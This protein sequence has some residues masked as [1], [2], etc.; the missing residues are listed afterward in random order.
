MK[1]LGAKTKS[2]KPKMANFVIDNG[3]YFDSVYES[4]TPKLPEDRLPSSFMLDLSFRTENADRFYSEQVQKIQD[5]LGVNKVVW[6]YKRGLDGGPV[7]EIYFY[8]HKKYPENSYENIL[9][10]LKPFLSFD[11]LIKTIDDDYYLISTEM[12]DK[13][14][15][16]LNVYRPVIPDKNDASD[17]IYLPDTPHYFSKKSDAVSIAYKIQSSNN[18]LLPGNTYYK[19]RIPRTKEQ[20]LDL[21]E[22]HTKKFFSTQPSNELLNSIFDLPFMVKGKDIN[23][24]YLVVEKPT[25]QAIGLYFLNISYDNLVNFLEFFNYP[26]DYIIQ[27]KKYRSRLEYLQMDMG[28]DIK[29]ENGKMVYQKPC[30]TGTF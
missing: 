25:R 23:L 17:R 16:C 22:K 19:V 12:T 6:G 28:F 5:K 4:Y 26:I 1:S 24:P 3:K 10:L 14:T 18:K 11:P 2:T 29:I 8:H 13:S 20:V 21:L 15:P 7:W 9:D 30:I 27:I